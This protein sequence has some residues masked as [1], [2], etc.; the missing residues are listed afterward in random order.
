MAVIFQVEFRHTTHI[1][2]ILSRT[3]IHEYL[4]LIAG[5]IDEG[6]RDGIFR[7]ELDSFFGAKALF[8]VLDEM[9]TDWIL[10][11]RNTRLTAVTDAVCEFALNGLRKQTTG[12]RR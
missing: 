1:L 9:A 11:K 12:G 2:E 6:K 7:K 3:R 4:K 5:I 10:S 8:G